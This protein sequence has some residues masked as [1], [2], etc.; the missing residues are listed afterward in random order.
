MELLDGCMAII[1]VQELEGDSAG[2]GEL[3]AH[4]VTDGLLRVI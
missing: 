1:G 2:F 4:V 3:G